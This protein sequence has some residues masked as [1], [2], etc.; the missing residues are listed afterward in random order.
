MCA[1][2]N[3]LVG[4]LDFGLCDRRLEHRLLELAL[5]RAGVDLLEALGDV[6]A[7]LRERVEAGS[8]GGEVIVDL[9]QVLGLDLVDRD[10]EL[11]LLAGQLRH[12][13][14]VGE[15]DRHRPLLAG[16][17]A[18][19]LL[20][21]SRHQPARAEL[22]QLIA[23]GASL[24]LRSTDGAH[25]VDHHVVAVL[26][27]ALH[28][29]ERRQPVAQPVDLLV[30]L[31]IVDLRL[32]AADL[33]S[34]VLAEPGRRAHADLDRERQRLA[35]LR[36]VADVELGLADRR[37]A[38]AVDRVRVPA[39]ERAANRLVED[40]VAAQPADHDRRRHLALAEAGYAHLAAELARGLLD[41][42][43]DLLGS[44]FGLDA[45]AR[46]GQLGDAGLDGVSHGGSVG[47]SAAPDGGALG[48][49]R[50]ET[51][52]WARALTG[53]WP[54]ATGP[55]AF[56]VAGADRRERVARWPTFAGAPRHDGP[57]RPS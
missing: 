47:W 1:R 22:D 27:R 9:G 21:E 32:A 34:L 29:V 37:D 12:R 19:E 46:L 42:P 45:D 51:I 13:I 35:L 30:D 55:G 41:A 28:G 43:L 38:G 39:P 25:V 53:C 15:R 23:P 50:A 8:L 56:L 26:G 36:Q 52:A 2:V 16:A 40:R 7:Q 31:G 17:R 11:R 20:L 18:R 10:L 49:V 5:E 14:V 4:H 48:V 6:L 54:A 44:D 33:E 57:T 24:E 3:Q